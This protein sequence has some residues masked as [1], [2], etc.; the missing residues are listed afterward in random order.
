MSYHIHLLP[1]AEEDYQ[2]IFEYIHKQS[3]QGADNWRQ[4]FRTAYFR[5]KEDPLFCGLAPESSLLNF[6]LRQIFFRTQSGKRYRAVFRID[7]KRVPIYRFRGPGQAPLLPEDL[8][9]K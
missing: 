3:P 1:D 7:G 5:L 4:A 9:S 6:E 2:H 8:P